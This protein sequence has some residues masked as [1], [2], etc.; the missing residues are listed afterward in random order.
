MT[1]DILPKAFDSV[2]HLEDVMSRPDAATLRDLE[3]VD[4]DIVIL[5]V[6]GKMGP[7]LARMARRAAPS[8]RIIGVARFSEPGL[9][10]RLDSWGVETVAC[11]L[12]DREALARLPDAANVVF[13][14]GHKFGSAGNEGFTWAMNAHVPALVAERYPHALWVEIAQAF[15]LGRLI[16]H[17]LGHQLPVRQF[18]VEL[19]PWICIDQRLHAGLGRLDAVM[20]R[21]VDSGGCNNAPL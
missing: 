18:I 12:L 3:E 10:D 15:G 6:G 19:E 11:D 13:M 5:G 2:E 14:A 1:M 17:Q 16:A 20:K 7:T 21:I 4:G 8:K 9:K